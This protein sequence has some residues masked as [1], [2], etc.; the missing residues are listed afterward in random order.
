V[1]RAIKR[2][3]KLRAQAKKEGGKGKKEKKE[4]E[5]EALSKES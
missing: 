5:T 4:K 3:R 2:G 1:V